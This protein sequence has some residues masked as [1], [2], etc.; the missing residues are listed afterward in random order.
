MQERVR[1]VNGSF[2]IDSAAGSGTRVRVAVPILPQ[3]KAR[4]GGDALLAALTP[5]PDAYSN[6][7]EED[8]CSVG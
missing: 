2:S 4:N 7:Y 8:I 6:L 5:H 1:L 3:P